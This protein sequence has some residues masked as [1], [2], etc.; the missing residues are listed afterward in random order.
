[1]VWRRFRV[2]GGIVSGIGVAERTY[3]SSR[4]S[5]RHGMDF[6]V[7]QGGGG[8]NVHAEQKYNP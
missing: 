1:M 2:G 3:D 4:S 5:C 8:L 6:G 7:C